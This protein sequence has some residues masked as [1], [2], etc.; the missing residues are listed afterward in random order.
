MEIPGQ[1]VS[2]NSVSNSAPQITSSINTVSNSNQSSST[3][4]QTDNNSDDPLAAIMNQTI[5]GGDNINTMFIQVNTSSYLSTQNSNIPT[6]N[7][8]FVKDNMKEEEGGA[9]V[10]TQEEAAPII[11]EDDDLNVTYTCTTCNKQVKG[12]VMLQAHTFQEHHD[13]P[14]FDASS[15]PDDKYACRVCLKL[16]T[17]NSDVKAHILRVHCGD[18]RYPCTTCGKR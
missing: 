18:R 11:Q 10:V 14:E 2:S 5:F 7:A 1:N 4:R 13:N 8:N 3:L 12:K 9:A 16:F 17:R 15:F 6:I